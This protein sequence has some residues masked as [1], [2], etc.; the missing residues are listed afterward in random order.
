MIAIVKTLEARKKQMTEQ[1]TMYDIGF[2]AALDT[3]IGIITEYSDGRKCIVCG[4]TEFMDEFGYC[5]RCN[6]KGYY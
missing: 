3:A 5:T 1:M 2:N 4:S 6:V